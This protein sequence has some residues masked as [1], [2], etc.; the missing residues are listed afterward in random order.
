[1]TGIASH[2]AAYSSDDTD[3]ADAGPSTAPPHVMGDR[4]FL[5]DD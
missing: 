2:E 3:M 4:S 5:H 1:M